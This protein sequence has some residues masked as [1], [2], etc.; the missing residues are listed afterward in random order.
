MRVSLPALIGALALTGCAYAG[1]EA[2]V[3]VDTRGDAI[4]ASDADYLRSIPGSTRSATITA[5]R[6]PN[7]ER[8][9][10]LVQAQGPLDDKQLA[11]LLRPIVAKLEVPKSRPLRLT[12]AVLGDTHR[13]K[14]SIGTD[15]G[16]LCGGFENRMYSAD[17][18]TWTY[19]YTWG[20]VIY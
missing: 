10:V 9:D 1:T 12:I 13:A 18:G 16:R 6:M 8:K 11:E 15:C 5:L 20:E 3:T 14:I 2:V 7:G 17:A 4:V 19:L